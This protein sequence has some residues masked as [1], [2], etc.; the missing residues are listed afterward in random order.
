MNAKLENLRDW[1]PARLY[2]HEQ[3]I[4]ADWWYMGKQRFTEPFFYNTIE[5]LPRRPFS[6]LFRHQLPVEFL[7]ELYE[8]NPGLAPSGFIFHMS[9][10]GSTLAAQMLA[11][12]PRNI[13]ISEPPSID[14]ILSLNRLHPSI[15]D[16]LRATL[17]KWIISA[18]GRKRR[19][20]EHFY[21]IKFD[22]WSTLDLNFIRRAFPEVPWIFLYR[23]PIEV[24]VSQLRER[25]SQMIP[26]SIGQILPGLDFL[27]A[28]QMPHE[29]YIARVLAQF[30][31][32][33]I[34]GV[35]NN[36]ALLV[37]YNQL[38]EAIDAI[39]E[40]FRVEYSPEEIESIKRAARFN[41]KTPRVDFTPDSAEKRK[42]ASEAAVQMCEKWLNPLYERLEKMRS[43]N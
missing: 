30:C 14:W 16:E 3:K 23:N 32:S 7:G 13:V 36:N 12:T 6:L 35:K 37:N 9:R 25:G 33:A 1:M 21:F 15:T 24:M 34:E 2:W 28:I 22:S 18:Y 17:L 38:P 29:E 43:E 26:G 40:H 4:F 11:S 10:C 31:E 41:A 19:A 5:T 20:K 42:Q 27:Q 8:R 39:I